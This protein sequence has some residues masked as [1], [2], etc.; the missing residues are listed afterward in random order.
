MARRLGRRRMPSRY[1]V[2]PTDGYAS[3]TADILSSSPGIVG[4]KIEYGEEG[5]MVMLK[6]SWF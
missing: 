3:T 2:T 5:G 6:D 4:L 1:Q